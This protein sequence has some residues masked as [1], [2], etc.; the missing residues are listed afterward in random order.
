M[1]RSLV[2]SEMCIRDRYQRRVR[3]NSMDI[4]ATP[5]ASKAIVDAAELAVSLAHHSVEPVHLACIL[6]TPGEYG[7]SVWEHLGP[8][9][10][11]HIHS[12]FQKIMTALPESLECVYERAS[13]VHRVREMELGLSLMLTL[14]EPSSAFLNVIHQAHKFQQQSGEGQLT[15][16]HL[17]RGLLQDPG[18]SRELMTSRDAIASQ[19]A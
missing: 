6:F 17:T 1:L 3:G 8:N 2:G 16:E 4:H 5:E 10:N 11:A 15:A 12:M 13:A 18:L 14:M 7:A 19:A 9:P